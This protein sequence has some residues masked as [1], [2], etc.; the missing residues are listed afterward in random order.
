MSGLGRAHDGGYAE[1]TLVQTGAVRAVGPTTLGWDVLGSLPEM[2]QTT[3]GSLFEALA[4]EK[5]D[6]LLVR[7]GTSSM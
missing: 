5:G 2:V 3:W 7:G 6:R 1:Y 4:I